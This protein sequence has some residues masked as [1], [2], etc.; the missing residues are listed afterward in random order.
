MSQSQPSYAVGERVFF[1]SGRGS[2]GYGIIREIRDGRVFID[3][4]PDAIKGSDY[5]VFRQPAKRHDAW[6]PRDY[7]LRS[8]QINTPPRPWFQGN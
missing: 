7:G 3:P 1:W 4:D 6:G 8:S 5:R 2:Q